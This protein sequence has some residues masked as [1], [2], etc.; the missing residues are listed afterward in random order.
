MLATIVHIKVYLDFAGH[1][2]LRTAVFQTARRA[3]RYASEHDQCDSQVPARRPCNQSLRR[4]FALV[5]VNNN[6]P[7]MAASASAIAG[8]F[9]V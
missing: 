2:P 4:A 7:A 6:A 3:R 9:F 5:T 1:D 8:F